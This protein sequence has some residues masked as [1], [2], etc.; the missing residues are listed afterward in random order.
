MVQNKP[1]PDDERQNRDIASTRR[2]LRRL[3]LEITAEA[4]VAMAALIL[5]LVTALTQIWLTASPPKISALPVEDGLFYWDGNKY[6]A[7]L[8]VAVQ[9]T[10]INTSSADHGDLVEKATLDIRVAGLR[11]VSFPLQSLIEPHLVDDPETVSAR[12][13]V[14]DRCLSLDGLVVVEPFGHLIALPGGGA[15]SD[16]LSFALTKWSCK[17][18]GNDCA[19]FMNF[20]AAADALNKRPLALRLNLKFR[21]AAPITLQCTLPVAIDGARLQRHRWISFGCSEAKS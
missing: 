21:T 8:A 17:G 3:N 20:A 16:Y 19:K 4:V 7:V 14:V 18:S 12:C 2:A 13:A 10:L 6:G 15:R 1:S 9:S 11:T 5:S